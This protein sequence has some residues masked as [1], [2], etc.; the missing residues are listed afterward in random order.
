MKSFNRTFDCPLMISKLLL[1]CDKVHK[2][3]FAEN[4]FFFADLQFSLM[5]ALGFHL[6]H[7][8][9]LLSINH[10]SHS[11]PKKKNTAP[12]IIDWTKPESSFIEMLWSWRWMTNQH[13]KQNFS[14]FYS[15]LTLNEFVTCIV[16]QKHHISF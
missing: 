1:S 4:R 9:L 12:I 10:I 11:Q 16:V 14:L 3:S 8:S 6:S 2:F 7:K 15:L 13:K 5:V